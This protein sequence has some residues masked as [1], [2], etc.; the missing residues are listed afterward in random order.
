MAALLAIST[1]LPAQAQNRA[2]QAAPLDTTSIGSELAAGQTMTPDQNLRSPNGQHNLYVDGPMYIAGP[3]GFWNYLLDAQESD[4]ANNRLV[5]QV[6]GKLVLYNAGKPLWWTGTA[7]NPGAKVA[8]SPMATSSSMQPR[9]G[10]CGPAARLTTASPTPGKRPIVARPS[11]V[12]VG[13]CT[14]RTVGTNWSCRRTATLCCTRRGGPSGRAARPATRGRTS[15]S[16]RTATW[17]S[18]AA[19]VR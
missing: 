19:R 12:Q 13:C 18:T 8:C 10:R 17:S 9:G 2:P 7:G 15:P 1:A 6:D 5:M 14:A 4:P 16:R 3:S 11:C